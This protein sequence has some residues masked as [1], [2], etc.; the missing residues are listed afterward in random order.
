MGRLATGELGKAFAVLRI[1]VALKGAN[2][3]DDVVHVPQSYVGAE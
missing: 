3:G 2:A 1:D